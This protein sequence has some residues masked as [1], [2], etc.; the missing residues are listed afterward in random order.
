MKL[1][2][3]TPGRSNINNGN[4]VTALRY[5]GILRRLG[6]RVTIDEHYEGASCDL[7][8]ALHARKSSDSILRFRERYPESPLVVVLTGTDLYRDLKTN[9]KA[10][11]SLE[12]ASRVVVLQGMGL[13]EIGS[14]L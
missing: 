4:R 12:V 7:L 8:I 1:R 9:G 6:H 5:A 13:E 3:I 10:R 2:L 14:R 11:H